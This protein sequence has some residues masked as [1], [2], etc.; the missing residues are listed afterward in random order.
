MKSCSISEKVYALAHRLPVMLFLLALAACGGDGAQEGDSRAD[1]TVLVWLAGD[2]DLS[3][4]VSRKAAAL[5]Q[6]YY[7]AAN[8]SGEAAQTASRLIIYADRRGEYPCLYEVSGRGELETIET[9]TPQNSASGETLRRVLT[10][11][12]ARCPA[13]SYGLIVFSHSTGWLPQGALDNPSGYGKQQETAPPVTRTMFDDNG[14]QMD[15]DEFAGQLPL[16]PDGSPY[17]YIVFESCFTAGV[18]TAY[19]LRDKADRLLVSSAEVLSPGF[20]EVYPDALELL[21]RRDADVTGFARAC[22]DSYDAKEGAYRSATLSVI[23]TDALDALAE[24][25]DGAL[26]AEPL[27]E[28]SAASL[29]RFNRHDYGLF[30]DLGE[31]AELFAPQRYPAI[32]SAIDAA[33]EYAAATPEFMRGYRNGFSIGHHCGLTLYMPQAAFPGLN[34]AYA[35]TEWSR[36]TAGER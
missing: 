36:R 7:K 12:M 8:G 23:R 1:R 4:E 15:M 22:F 16:P 32:C 3:G 26:T 13:R 11:M 28:V 18:E 24:A 14:T 6:G 2:N 20:E 10:D 25:M 34:A 31:C 19:A 5:A 29:Q 33:V 27:D 35:D 21:L 30:F 17:D 9:Y